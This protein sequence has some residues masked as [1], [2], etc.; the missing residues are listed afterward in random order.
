MW[1]YKNNGFV[2]KCEFFE[3]LRDNEKLSNEDIESK[4]KGFT[5]KQIENYSRQY[6]DND[7]LIEG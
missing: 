1:N 2:N 4:F 6:I 3:Y 5:D 7:Y